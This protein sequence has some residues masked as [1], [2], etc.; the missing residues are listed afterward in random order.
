MCLWERL[1]ALTVAGWGPIDVLCSGAVAFCS[2]GE[3]WHLGQ[4]GRW[5]LSAHTLTG[6]ST[7]DRYCKCSFGL[8]P[9]AGF[10]SMPRKAKLRP[11]PKPP[12]AFPRK[13][14]PPRPTDGRVTRV[15]KGHGLWPPPASAPPSK[16]SPA[17]RPPPRNSSAILMWQIAPE[18]PRHPPPSGLRRIQ[19]AHC[20]L[21]PQQQGLLFPPSPPSTASASPALPRHGY[22]RNEWLNCLWWS[23]RQG[24][25]LNPP[26]GMNSSSV[27]LLPGVFREKDGSRKQDRPQGA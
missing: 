27:P 25:P 21:G 13:L 6:V 7:S 10:T 22:N 8:I 12:A 20:V 9:P 19:S 17:R 23:E 15:W 2:G 5:V 26:R 24:S 18:N 1:Y 3:R 11:V 16:N 14:N 4:C